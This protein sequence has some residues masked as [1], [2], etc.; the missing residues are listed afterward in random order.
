MGSERSDQVSQTALLLRPIHRHKVQINV[1]S[2]FINWSASHLLREG[3]ALFQYSDVCI[4]F[5]F[6]VKLI[7]VELQ[8]TID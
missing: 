5:G 8:L 7:N 3:D 6:S 1:I 4:D 2:I